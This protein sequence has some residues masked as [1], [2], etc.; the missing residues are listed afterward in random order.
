MYLAFQLG[1]SLADMKLFNMNMVER[2]MNREGG[3]LFPIHVWFPV[4]K[5]V[6]QFEMV[7]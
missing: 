5:N 7:V 2:Q 3:L 6:K 1:M 4:V